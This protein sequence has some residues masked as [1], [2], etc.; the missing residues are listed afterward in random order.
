MGATVIDMG[1]GTT[2]IGVFAHGHLTHIDAVAVGG[3]HITMDV[4]RG[5]S[6]RV[7]IA[8]RLKTLHGSALSSPSDERDMISAPHVD[9]DTTPNHVPKSQLI[10]IIR[11]RVEEILELVRD[12]LKASGHG[13][14][15]NSRIVLTGGGSQLTGMAELARRIMGGQVRIG[16]P[17]GIKGLPEAARGP[18][19]PRLSACWSIR[20]WRA[21]SD[22]FHIVQSRPCV[23]SARTCSDFVLTPKHY[24]N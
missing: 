5:L 16:R 21:Q 20:R 8:E 10:G 24:H 13:P 15:M 4:A 9:D 14:D 12:R 3:N 7:A 6:T 22:S 23:L 19:S 2:S 18:P 1:G 11:P 17:L